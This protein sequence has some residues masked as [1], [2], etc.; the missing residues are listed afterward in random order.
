MVCL[1]SVWAR[2]GGAERIGSILRALGM[3]VLGVQRGVVEDISGTQ[4]VVCYWPWR[5]RG[6][7][8]FG[9]DGANYVEWQ[10]SMGPCMVVG[11]WVLPKV[12]RSG[13]LFAISRTSTRS[14]RGNLRHANGS[15]LLA[16]E[17]P[18]R[19]FFGYAGANYVGCGDVILFRLEAG[20][21]S[22]TTRGILPVVGDVKIEGRRESSQ[23][24]VR[25]R[26]RIRLRKQIV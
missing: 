7:I 20:A 13:A 8:F 19:D 5:G 9:N 11:C 4:M 15:M 14:G 12:W 23:R 25:R 2:G 18:R 10:C 6:G 16:L 24:F 22:S 21:C 26:E 17:R 3:E 1:A